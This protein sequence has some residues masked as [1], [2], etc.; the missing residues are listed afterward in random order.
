MLLY[1]ARLFDSPRVQIGLENT[2]V[3][4]PNSVVKYKK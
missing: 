4:G 2:G 3:L 1:R